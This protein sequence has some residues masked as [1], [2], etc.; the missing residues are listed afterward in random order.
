VR[1]PDEAL[2]LEVRQVLVH[3]REGLKPKLLGDLLEARRVALALDMLRD[4]I[5]QFAL[6]ARK[7]HTHS[8]KINRR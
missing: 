6:T 2:P 5:E 8:P 4:E 7:R 3:G 1:A